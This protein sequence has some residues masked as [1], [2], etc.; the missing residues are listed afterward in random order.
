M[1]PIRKTN[2]FCR[3]QLLLPLSFQLF[4]HAL[5][6]NFDDA[7]SRDGVVFVEGG[8][9]L[10]VVASDDLEVVWPKLFSV[11]FLNAIDKLNRRRVAVLCE[12]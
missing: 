4:F 5:G 1:H 8:L 7:V 12:E 2:N 3:Q 6:V 10:V 11:Q 9:L